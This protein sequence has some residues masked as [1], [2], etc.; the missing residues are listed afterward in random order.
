MR[1]FRFPGYF[2]W[3]TGWRFSACRRDTTSE[4]FRWEWKKFQDGTLIFHILQAPSACRSAQPEGVSVDLS[5][6]TSNNQFRPSKSRWCPIRH[7]L[8]FPIGTRQY[9]ATSLDTTRFR[10]SHLETINCSPS[11]GW[12]AMRT[13]T[14]TFFSRLKAMHKKLVS[15]KT[16]G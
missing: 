16:Q 13:W 15:W 2:H 14:Q 8:I 11:M 10:V 9:V 1:R 4:K 3:I 7:A 5:S 12:R 6:I